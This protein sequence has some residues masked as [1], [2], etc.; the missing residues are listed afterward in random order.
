[1]LGDGRQF[2]RLRL[3]QPHAISLMLQ[4]GE[5][6]REHGERIENAPEQNIKKTDHDEVEHD[7]HRP[8]RDGVVP[9][10]GDLIGRLADNL[11]MPDPQAVDGHGDIAGLDRRRDERRKPMRGGV[12]LGGGAAGR[13]HRDGRARGVADH[14]PDMAHRLQLRR[15]RRQKLLGRKLLAG[16]MDGV[17]DQQVGKAHRSRHLDAR[18]HARAQDDDAAG[19]EHGDDI[20]QHECEQELG[21]NRALIPERTA[22]ALQQSRRLRR[23]RKR[24]R[25]LYADRCLPLGPLCYAA[26]VSRT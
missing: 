12:A 16:E 22:P 8:D 7:G 15:Q 6:I 17:F 5:A 2:A 13:R 25:G 9:H 21:A 1:M 3:R 4:V 19:N 11:D 23:A 20:D 14:E 18:L 10:L 24:G 26:D